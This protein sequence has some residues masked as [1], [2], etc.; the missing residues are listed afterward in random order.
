M[1]GYATIGASDLAKSVAF[2]QD[3]L[4]PLGPQMMDF[5]DRMKVITGGNGAMLGICTPYDEK[6]PAPGN[7]NMI[8]IAANDRDQVQAMYDKAISLGATDEGAPGER[9]PTFFGAYFR[10]FDGNK[11]CLFKMG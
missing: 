9:A 11:V 1:I 3:V 10:D 5:S 4:G 7:G 6:D 8:A 2:Y